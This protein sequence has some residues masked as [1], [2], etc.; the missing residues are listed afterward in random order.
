MSVGLTALI[1]I[2]V[3]VN[4]WTRTKG[5]N[6]H[7]TFMNKKFW[8]TQIFTD[9]AKLF[10]VFSGNKPQMDDNAVSL[11]TEYSDVY[12]CGSSLFTVIL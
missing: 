9:E 12:V 3:S 6:I 4:I 10:F 5:E 11:K 1:I 7:R 2:V 8:W